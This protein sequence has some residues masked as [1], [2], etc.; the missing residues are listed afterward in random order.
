MDCFMTVVSWANQ[1]D[2][3]SWVRVSFLVNETRNVK[4]VTIVSKDVKIDFM[5]GLMIITLMVMNVLR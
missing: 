1:N 2:W 3:R 5:I 4:H